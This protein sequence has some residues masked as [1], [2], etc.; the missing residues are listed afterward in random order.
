MAQKSINNGEKAP[1]ETATRWGKFKGKLSETV[2]N[3]AEKLIKKSMADSNIGATLDLIG[4]VN[5]DARKEAVQWLKDNAKSYTNGMVKTLCKKAKKEDGI[6]TELFIDAYLK[7]N[8]KEKNRIWEG[9]SKELEGILNRVEND[10]IDED[11]KNA[12][13]V[14]VEI[15]RVDPHAE[16]MKAWEALADIVHGR[17]GSSLETR[18]FALDVLEESDYGEVEFWESVITYEG[19]GDNNELAKHGIKLILRE[20]TKESEEFLLKNL[21]GVVADRLVE[22]NC[23]RDRDFNRRRLVKFTAY[24]LSEGTD[25]QKL[26]L[27]KAINS[28]KIL[29]SSLKNQWMEEAIVELIRK[30]KALDPKEYEKTA[31]K[32]GILKIKLEA[33]E[34]K[35]DKRIEELEAENKEKEEK[36]GVCIE[37]NEEKESD[38]YED[39]AVKK[40]SA[41]IAE[42]EDALSE[43]R[44][45]LGQYYSLKDAVK[46][47][48]GLLLSW[49]W[50]DLVKFI[51]IVITQD[52]K[53]HKRRVDESNI[54][55]RKLRELEIRK[56][57]RIE[58]L[59]A[60]NK[61]KGKDKGIDIYSD[62]VVEKLAVEMDEILNELPV[63]EEFLKSY[64]KQKVLMNNA[65]AFLYNMKWCPKDAEKDLYELLEKGYE[66]GK[67]AAIL[68]RGKIHEKEAEKVIAAVLDKMKKADGTSGYAQLYMSLHLLLKNENKKVR[69]LSI[70]GVKRLYEKEKYARGVVNSMLMNAEQLLNM[71]D[72][73]MCNQ[74]MALLNSLEFTGKTEEI[75]KKVSNNLEERIEKMLS[76]ANIDENVKAAHVL[77]ILRTLDGAERVIEEVA[78]PELR[79][80]LEEKEELVSS[81]EEKFEYVEAKQHKPDIEKLKPILEILEN[82]MRD[83]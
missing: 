8:E 55:Q 53:E 51:R 27:I 47:A 77:V 18:K 24:A 35:K 52:K 71:D 22:V 69:E 58:K 38:I 19:N 67:I 5:G 81:L 3:G 21:D 9:M 37:K 42:L 46:I 65:I 82:V 66:P 41:E 31:K 44:K 54:L 12:V 4:K 28:S 17:T 59:E 74:G 40:I 10:I 80:V 7:L 11:L 57:R 70:I 13:K 33:L 25:E 72:P 75:K 34:T 73:E 78:I 45:S 63:H 32:L 68:M 79:D 76:S 50:R 20:H 36:T 1:S 43:H 26:I 14:Y 16:H 39:E 61:R 2:T 64:Q 15:G 23:S 6:W 29:P 49:E 30:G 60:E 56:D 48:I 83:E 62:D